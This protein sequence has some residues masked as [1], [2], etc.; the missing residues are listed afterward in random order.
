MPNKNETSGNEQ[1]KPTD[2]MDVGEPIPQNEAILPPNQDIRYQP[3]TSVD[4]MARQVVQQ[5]WPTRPQNWFNL[6][7]I[8]FEAHNIRSDRQRYLQVL[9]AISPE[10][11]DIIADIL[12]DAPQTNQYETLKCALLTRLA[13]SDEAQLAKLI[14]GQDLGDRRPSEALRHI[15]LLAAGK[16]AQTIIKSLWIQKLPEILRI[17]LLAQPDTTSFE[18]LA[19]MA[20]KMH[21][22]LNGNQI[23]EI[24]HHEVRQTR[25]KECFARDGNRRSSSSSTAVEERLA[26]LE[27]LFATSNRSRSRGRQFPS[28]SFSKSRK[29][30]TSSAS[31]T[32]DSVCWFHK[33]YGSAA[34]KCRP[35]CSYKTGDMVPIIQKND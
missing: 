3:G 6:A 24:R 7:E 17:A 18:D 9:G 32:G 30:G 35:P 19:K 5:F 15:R 31:Q 8:Q 26:R 22:S 20:D 10:T 16:F 23:N 2:E 12:A 28:R 27:A 1:G 13:P 29:R 14:R 11:S 34:R 4:A 33:S 21:A 25:P